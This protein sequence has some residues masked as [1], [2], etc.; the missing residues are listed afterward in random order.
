MREWLLDLLVEPVTGAPLRLQNAKY[1]G[2]RII[3][4]TLIAEP[5]KQRFPIIGGIPRF[6]NDS[7]AHSFGFQWKRHRSTQFD[8]PQHLHSRER[9]FGETEFDPSA[10]QRGLT[11]EAGCGSG[12]FLEVASACGGRVVG[13]DLSSAVEA[14]EEN[15]RDRVNVGIVQADILRL[16]FREHSFDH[17]YCL[18]VLQHTP[19]PLASLEALTRLPKIGGE[20]GIWW[21]KRYWWTFLHQKYLLRPLLRRVPEESLYRFIRAYAPYLL[22][23]SQALGRLPPLGPPH[24][25]VERVLPVANRH[26]VPGLSAEAVLE[27]S[28]LDTF[29]WYSPRFD[30]PQTWEAVQA[31]LSK[32]GFEYHR[33]RR[34]GLKATRVSTGAPQA[35]VRADAARLLIVIP[36]LNF[37]GA[38]RVAALLSR[39]V[40]GETF[41]A[42]LNPAAPTYATGGT[43]INLGLPTTSRLLPK[44]RNLGT[45]AWKLARLKHELGITTTLSFLD[46]PSILNALTRRTERLIISVRTFRS[47]SYQGKSVVASFY[48]GLMW[49]SLRRAHSV[50]ANSKGIARDLEREFGLTPN[51][52]SV[53]YNPCDLEA[54]NQLAA[55][56]LG[57]HQWIFDRPVVV[58]VGRMIVDKGHDAL[59][60]AFAQS[61]ISN[62]Q[63]RLVL[64]GDGELRANL[65]TLARDLRLKT[66]DAG[67]GPSTDA[68]VVFCGVQLNP[69]RFVS[70]ATLFALSSF[71]EGFPNVLLEAMACG[72]PV[73]S[74]DC[75]TGPRELLAPD[76]DIAYQTTGIEE[77]P[78]GILVP[79]ID[80]RWRAATEPLT[81]AEQSLSKAI[82]MLSGD[83]EL[84]CKYKTASRVRA[85]DFSADRIV[86]IWQR[87]LSR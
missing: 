46:A 4:G 18:G 30:Q 7:Y 21:Y 20:L 44:L 36:N 82:A 40:T 5:S 45:G 79:P 15:L 55:E 73:V 33:T 10:L 62:P 9:F 64:I 12:R 74:T 60:R 63:L 32:A 41:I 66:A 67:R 77:T 51:Q 54:I 61:R 69:F 16:P 68:D 48:R 2:D 81:A 26:D 17:V 87:E 39:K 1:D 85:D 35:P 25:L 11:L 19:D 53:I 70:H 75:R 43:L 59:L 13:V 14:A 24:N 80:R 72:V 84:R 78:Y 58:T 57:E 86:P 65:E 34:R 27:W 83:Q 37:G 52:V 76:T 71:R 6:T 22:P 8:S 31:V 50:V 47:P 56:P 38:E 49:L 42:M 3:E 28:V 23:V 29:D